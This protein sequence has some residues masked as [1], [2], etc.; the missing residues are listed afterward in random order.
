MYRSIEYFIKEAPGDITSGKLLSTL[1]NSGEASP[2]YP[3]VCNLKSGSL[4]FEDRIWES[5]QIDGVNVSSE[6]RSIKL[7][8]KRQELNERIWFTTSSL[9]ES[10]RKVDPRF[11]NV[12][13]EARERF[14]SGRGS[15]GD[16]LHVP[17][18]DIDLHG[19]ADE[20]CFIVNGEKYLL[21]GTALAQFL[22]GSFT[23]GNTESAR[24]L[25]AILL[26]LDLIRVQNWTWDTMNEDLL[27]RAISGLAAP[28]LID[29]VD[30][31][32][33]LTAIRSTSAKTF[34]AFAWDKRS[35]FGPL[36][37]LEI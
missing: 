35:G 16:K 37:G 26:V 33:L 32:G 30:K 20:S 21:P 34:D 14:R 2:G 8:W 36:G 23:Y 1:G 13:S 15:F 22:A 24:K 19:F 18:A 17:V 31:P 10:L 12:V 11:A 4:Y 28:Q 5:F 27:T 3:I 6:T 7:H 25:S 9:Y 29:H